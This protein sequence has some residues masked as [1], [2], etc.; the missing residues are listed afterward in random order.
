MTRYGRVFTPK[1]TLDAEALVREA[2]GKR[3]KFKG[4]VSVCMRFTL[5]GT[6][7]T[8]TACEDTGSKLKGDIDNYVKTILDGLNGAAWDDDKQVV[9]IEAE[10]A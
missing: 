2:W 3:R 10:K 5:D 4:A 1:R 8:V 6:E 9:F 7:I